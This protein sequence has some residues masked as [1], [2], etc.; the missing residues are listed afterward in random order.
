[1]AWRKQATTVTTV[2]PVPTVAHSPHG[3]GLRKPVN[4][5]TSASPSEHG[6]FDE[7]LGRDSPVSGAQQI[8]KV[9]VWEWGQVRT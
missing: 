2:S 8:A 6:H 7:V 9:C 4:P 1:M 3:Q 5:R